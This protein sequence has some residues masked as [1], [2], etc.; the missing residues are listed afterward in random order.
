MSCSIIQ[1]TGRRHAFNYQ[2]RAECLWLLYHRGLLHCCLCRLVLT[3]LSTNPYDEHRAAQYPGVCFSLDILI[4]GHDWTKY[5][6]K[7]RPH[8][9]SPK[10]EEYAHI[11]FDLD[12]G[13]C[14]NSRSTTRLRN[15]QIWAAFSIGIPNKSSYGS[16]QRTRPHRVRPVLLFLKPLSGIRSSTPE[17]SLTLI[18]HLTF[19]TSTQHQNPKHPDRRRVRIHRRSRRDQL[20]LA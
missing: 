13:T 9:Y 5:R 20:I 2:S 1:Q 8:Y 11:K 14:L 15:E 4:F 6:V 10:R 3:P 19:T 18:R 17:A 7:G 16:K 12:A